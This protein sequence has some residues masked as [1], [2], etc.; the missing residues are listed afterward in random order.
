MK[1]YLSDIENFAFKSECP[2][3]IRSKTLYYDGITHVTEVSKKSW[4]NWYLGRTCHACV[5]FLLDGEEVVYIGQTT[6]E[7]R[8]RQHEKDKVFTDVWFVP[9]RQP[10]QII[11]EN[12]LL[13][14]YRTRYNKQHPKIKSKTSVCDLRKSKYHITQEEIDK[15]YLSL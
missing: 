13:S 1:L 2:R 3:T 11:L 9:V 12:N 6:K 10:Y 15:I 7:T 8:T 5:Y 4:S 14:K